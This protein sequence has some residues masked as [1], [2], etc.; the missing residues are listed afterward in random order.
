[1]AGARQLQTAARVVNLLLLAAVGIAAA[2]VLWALGVARRLWTIAGAA[3]LLGAAGFA[4]QSRTHQPGKPVEADVVPI[5][6]DPGMVAFREA[7]FAP[8]RADSLALAT[9]D[10]RLQAGNAHAAA[11][12]LRADIALRPDDATLWSALGYVLALHDRGVSPAAKFAF[13]RA[14]T[15]A[16]RTP[17]PP[18]FL[19]M[20]HVD[21]GDLAAARPAWAYALA[22]TPKDA[23]YRADI[24]ERVAAVDRFLRMAAAQRAAGVVP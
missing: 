15:L 17:G 1:M 3:L 16:P 4:L 14:M 22:A 20:A 13:R 8:S 19:G 24:A 23:P 12:G 9:A 2:G 11:E 18:F 21:A 6:V 5:P 10:A 7:V